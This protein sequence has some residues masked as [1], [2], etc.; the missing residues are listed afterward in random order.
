MELSLKIELTDR[1]N[2]GESRAL[3]NILFLMFCF[4]LF[5]FSTENLGGPERGPERGPE[6]GP[7]RGSRKGGPRF[8]YTLSQATLPGFGWIFFELNHF[9]SICH[10]QN[11]E[12]FLRF[13]KFLRPL[14]CNAELC[15]VVFLCLGT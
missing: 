6:G 3:F 14:D 8:V 11:G 2:S 1:R 4:F 7:E 13:R 15:W 5:F 12:V 10:L 9:V